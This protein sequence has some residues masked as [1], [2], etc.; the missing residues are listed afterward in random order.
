MLLTGYK[1]VIWDYDGVIQDSMP[2]RERGFSMIFDQYPPHQVD[3]LLAYHHANGGLSRFNKIKYFYNTILGKEITEE[4]VYAY[5]GRFSDVMRKA[6][7]DKSLLISDSVEFIKNNYDKYQF[8]IASGSEQ[9]ELRFLLQELGLSSYFKTVYGSPVTK[10]EN[11]K[12]I[13][14]EN[15]YNPAETCLVGDSINDYDACV[16]NNISFIGYNNPAL[17]HLGVGYIS[18]FGV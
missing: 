18:K 9:N 2:T 3:E 16:A 7:T 17:S 4:E 14:A 1:N 11:V 10:I 5:A 15:G 13:I 6:L 8:H 12:N